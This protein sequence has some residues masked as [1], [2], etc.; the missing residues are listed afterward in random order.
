MK[1]GASIV[2]TTKFLKHSAELHIEHNIIDGELEEHLKHKD[3]HKKR[4]LLLRL[5]K[6]AQ[7]LIVDENLKQTIIQKAQKSVH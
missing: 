3:A 4:T 7:N 2:D 1:K 6:G 5:E